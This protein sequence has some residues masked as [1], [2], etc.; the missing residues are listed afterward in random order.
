MTIFFKIRV[1][2]ELNANKLIVTFLITVFSYCVF[3]AERD[4]RLDMTT[5][6]QDTH[7]VLSKW[8]N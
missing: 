8:I 7:G 2:L 6:S 5:V 1:F 4:E 3:K